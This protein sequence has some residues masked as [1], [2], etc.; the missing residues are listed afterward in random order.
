MD[1]STIA[2]LGSSLSSALTVTKAVLGMKIDQEVREA[3]SQLQGSLIAAQTAALESLAE[4]EVLFKK[5]MELEAKINS[6][7]DWKEKSKSFNSVEFSSGAFAYQS[8]EDRHPGVYCAKCFENERASRLQEEKHKNG[9][10]RGRCLQCGSDFR[11]S[12]GTISNVD[13]G[14]RSWMA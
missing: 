9:A 4:R 11:F 7:E 1:I 8:S 10:H 2:G 14:S 13:S 12:S 5:V 3:V 6:T